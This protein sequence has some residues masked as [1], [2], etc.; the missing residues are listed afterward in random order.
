MTIT[1]KLSSEQEHLLRAGVAEQDAQTVREV[2][3]QAVDS[4]VEGL[5]RTSAPP[6]K[7]TAL[8]A[9][10]DK[11]ATGFRDA[12]ALSDEAVSRTGIYVEQ[13]T[14]SQEDREQAV[15]NLL[16]LSRKATSGSGGRRWTRE[17]LHER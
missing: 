13:P 14:S 10:L 9:L 12:P 16:E 15:R 7:A 3:L 2:L 1:L 11:I 17:E 4:T 5:L 6:P 8:P